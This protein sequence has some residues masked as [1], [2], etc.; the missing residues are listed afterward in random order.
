MLLENAFYKLPELMMSNSY[1]KGRVEAMVVQ[2]MAIDLKKKI[3][4]KCDIL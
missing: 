3:L 2:Y 4:E 1:G